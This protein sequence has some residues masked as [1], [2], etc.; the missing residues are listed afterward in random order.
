MGET[1]LQLPGTSCEPVPLHGGRV[2]HDLWLA[3]SERGGVL[4]GELEY[5]RELFDEAGA[6]RLAEQYLRLLDAVLSDADTP[7]SRLD[8]LG[9]AERQFVLQQCNATQREH[10]LQWC[11]HELVQQQAQRSADAIAVRA[12]DH[13]LAHASWRR[14]Q[15]NWRTT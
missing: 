12:G 10:P 3:F 13:T 7:L 6:Q 11:L 8:L 1:G 14:A 9:D 2:R 15:I 5:A 4:Q